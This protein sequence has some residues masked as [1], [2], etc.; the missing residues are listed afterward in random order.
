[1]K[2]KKYIVRDGYIFTFRYMEHGFPIY[3]SMG[4]LT[5]ADDSEIRNGFDTREEV[6]KYAKERYGHAD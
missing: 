2:M 4:G 3:S 1:M 6:E 5:V